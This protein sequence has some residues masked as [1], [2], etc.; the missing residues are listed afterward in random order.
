MNQQTDRTN[1]M[2][3]NGMEWNGMEGSRSESIQIQ[4]VLYLPSKQA[5]STVHTVSI[6][7]L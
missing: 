1:G 4:Y 3:W 5:T 7:Y 2:E 6:H